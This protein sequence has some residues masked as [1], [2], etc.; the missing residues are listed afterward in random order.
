[1]PKFRGFV[2]DGATDGDN[3]AG[4]RS[5]CITA[6]QPAF[7]YVRGL[8]LSYLLQYPSRNEEDG[9]DRPLYDI[10]QDE[11]GMMME[12]A[13]QMSIG[14]PCEPEEEGEGMSQYRLRVRPGDDCVLEQSWDGGATWYFAY[15]F[16]QCIPQ[17]PTITQVSNFYQTFNSSVEQYYEQFQEHYE[18]SVTD[19]HPDLGYGVDSDDA[20]RDAALCYT[21]NYLVEQ[22]CASAL[23]FYDEVDGLL[24]T[25]KIA[26][27]LAAALGALVGLA[28][29][30]TT[31]APLASLASGATAAAAGIALGAAIGEALYNIVISVARSDFEN[32][33]AKAEIACAIYEAM[34][35]QN[36]NFDYFQ[37]SIA[38]YEPELAEAVGIWQYA[39]LMMQEEATYAAFTEQLDYAFRMAKAGLIVTE[40]CACEEEPP[41]YDREPTLHPGGTCLSGYAGSFDAGGTNWTPLGGGY[42]SAQATWN[43]TDYRVTLKDIEDRSFII[44]D[45]SAPG[46]SGCFGWDA[47]TGG[48][49]FNG[50]SGGSINP[51]TP[52]TSW[53]VT[54]GSAVTITFHFAAP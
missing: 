35:G 45:I 25:V 29:G 38:G 26:A 17:P 5:I 19:L 31:S 24:N 11:R 37:I 15:D 47:V 23:K 27:A 49:Y 1:M 9:T 36:A 54:A 22:L 6:S 46:T 20:L 53:F 21:A 10:D 43:G 14:S 40:D 7:D 4:V 48:C 41:G 13:M 2:W 12:I 50:C 34:K 30:G 3:P 33:E 8:L 39:T 18:D 51:G 32:V 42:W 16:S 28:T 44:S 52:V